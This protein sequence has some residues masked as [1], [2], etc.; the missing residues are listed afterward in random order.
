[1]K[2][3]FSYLMGG[4]L[5]AACA[6]TPTDEISG[7]LTGLETDTLL[8]QSFPFMGATERD[9]K[10]DTVVATGGKFAFNVGDSVPKQVYIYPKP[11]MQ[12]GPDGRMPM[13]RTM[14]VR[15]VLVPGSPVTVK[16]TVDDYVLGGSPVYD[17]Y[18]AANALLAD[19]EAQA[20]SIM[21]MCMEMQKNGASRDSISIAYEPMEGIEKAMEDARAGYVR[22]NSGKD[23]A[24]LVLTEVRD[25][26]TAHELLESL[27][28][29]VRTGALYTLYDFLKANND[30]TLARLEAKE[31]IKEGAEAPDFTLKDINGKDFTLSSLRGSK[32]VV[33]DF[34]GSWCGWCIKGMPDMKKYYDKY[35]SKLEIVGVDCNDTEEAWKAAVKKHELP[36]LHVRNEGN[37]DVSVLYGIEGYPTKIVLDK[38]GKIAKVIVGEDPAFYTYLDSLMK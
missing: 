13:V 12:P 14:P 30:K 10:T 2:R 37:P 38:E 31:K 33:L 23:A 1:M 8:V 36:W 15:L 27:T 29:P 4:C 21:K 6:G 32:Y 16:G 24:L 5:L 7:E 9:V 34:W 18:E 26:K 11:S 3:L 25:P 17:D 20:D 19:Y 22:Q 35:K 28:E